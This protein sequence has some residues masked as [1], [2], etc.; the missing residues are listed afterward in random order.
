M[1]GDEPSLANP[2]AMLAVDTI[3]SADNTIWGFTCAEPIDDALYLLRVSDRPPAEPM[4][5]D[6][7]M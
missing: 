1:V 7:F 3:L 5:N 2:Q 6:A 4:L